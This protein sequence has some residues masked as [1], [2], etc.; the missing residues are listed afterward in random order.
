MVWT[1]HVEER[2]SCDKKSVRYE[3]R[4]YKERE[5][6]KKRR[7]DLVKNNEY[8]KDEDGDDTANPRE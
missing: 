1:C 7:I 5:R 6:P 8:H 2:M 4:G 3:C